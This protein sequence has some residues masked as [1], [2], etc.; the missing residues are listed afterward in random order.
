MAAEDLF[1]LIACPACKGEV[2]KRNDKIECL[3]CFR[4]Y[5]IRDGIIV[6]LAEEA[7]I[8]ENKDESK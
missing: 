8:D 1:K 2:V 5:P 6:M 4:K 7:K 3:K